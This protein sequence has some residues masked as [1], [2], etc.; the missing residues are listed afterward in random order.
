MVCIVQNSNVS[1]DE[2]ATLGTLFD[3]ARFCTDAVRYCNSSAPPSASPS[4]P[5]P[6]TAY[7]SGA[8]IDLANYTLEGTILL[9][10]TQIALAVQQQDSIGNE[11]RAAQRARRDLKELAGDLIE[12][13]LEKPGSNSDSKLL[14]VMKAFMLRL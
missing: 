6:V 12:E 9:M 3:L 5:T 8:F 2:P 11:S 1:L 4:P 14:E 13:F 7:D 10:S